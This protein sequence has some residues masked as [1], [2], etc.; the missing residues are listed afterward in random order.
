MYVT[1]FL[2]VCCNLLFAVS[3]LSVSKLPCKLDVYLYQF[4]LMVAI[5][6]HRLGNKQVS[7]IPNED[8]CYVCCIEG[9]QICSYDLLQCDTLSSVSPVDMQLYMITEWILRSASS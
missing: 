3:S 7:Y 8:R 9:T 6:R 1:F 5:C 4:M 2:I